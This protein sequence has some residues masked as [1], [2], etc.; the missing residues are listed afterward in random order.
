MKRRS[1]PSQPRFAQ[2]RAARGSFGGLCPLPSR[3]VPHQP[4]AFHSG[5]T[6]RSQLGQK[7]GKP[8]ISRK[9]W[10]VALHQGQ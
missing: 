5:R 6:P 7:S 10:S 2:L 1:S 3:R 4:Q 9:L 8:L